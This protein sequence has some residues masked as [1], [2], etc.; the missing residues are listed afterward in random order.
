MGRKIVKIV[1][2]RNKCIGAASCMSTAPDGFDLDDEGKA[3]LKRGY[4]HLDQ[5]LLALAAKVCPTRAIYAYDEDGN[6]IYPESEGAAKSVAPAAA[7]SRPKDVIEE[8]DDFLRI[9]FGNCP[10]CGRRYLARVGEKEWCKNC[11]W[12]LKA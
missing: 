10:L 5:A 11:G 9:E 7:E 1:I 2:D 4:E 8:L 12:R 3:V 6:Q